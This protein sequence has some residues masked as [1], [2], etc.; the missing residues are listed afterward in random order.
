[1]TTCARSEPRVITA[2]DRL[3]THLSQHL[4][5]SLY[6]TL[7]VSL[8][9]PNLSES[10][11]LTWSLPHSQSLCGSLTQQ[12]KEEERRKGEEENEMG[13][14]MGCAGEKKEE[15]KEKKKRKNGIR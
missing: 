14:H 13:V 7:S 8:P 6:L 2:V 5:V 12:N 11:P 10:P 1:M 4:S 15:R 3:Q 9:S